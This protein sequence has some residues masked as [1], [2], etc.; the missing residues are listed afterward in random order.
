M[1]DNADSAPFH[2]EE[3]LRARTKKRILIGILLIV[4][5]LFLLIAI[6]ILQS[7]ISEWPFAIFVVLFGAVFSGLAI[8]LYYA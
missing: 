2:G 3:E 8:F 6:L 4:S 1:E 7:F 5:P